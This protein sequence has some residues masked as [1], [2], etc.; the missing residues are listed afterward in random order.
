M[1][2]PDLTGEKV[3]DT[4]QRLLQKSDDGQIIDGTGSAFTPTS[5]TITGSLNTTGSLTAFDNDVLIGRIATNPQQPART[6]TIHSY[7]DS[8]IMFRNHGSFSKTKLTSGF[9]GTLT[10]NEEGTSVS[11]GGRLVLGGPGD[12]GT[13]KTSYLWVRIDNADD[14]VHIY[15]GA[16][17]LT[18][19]SE[20]GIERQEGTGVNY[21]SDIALR[22]A[23]GLSQHKSEYIFSRKGMFQ[24]QDAG[25]TVSGSGQVFVNVATSSISPIVKL[26]TFS[27]TF[28]VSGSGRFT[29][30]LSVAG[31]TRTLYT[32]ASFVYTSDN[33]T[34]VTQSYE[35]GTQQITDITYTGDNPQTI[36][37]TGSDGINK[38][39]TIV[40]DGDNVSEIRVT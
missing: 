38:L 1:A 9:S 17:S 33:I 11:P 16:N 35:S 31:T 6:L 3:N 25:F 15:L 19:S 36:A 40:Y 14:A 10:L 29:D 26:N 7:N 18:Y 32:S 4:Y 21:E 23:A 27:E 5:L 24:A 8:A 22:A 2:L 30:A 39:Y 13:N 37:V 12:T 20:I 28:V 34:Q